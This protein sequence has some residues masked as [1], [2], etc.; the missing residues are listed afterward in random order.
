MEIDIKNIKEINNRFC[1]LVGI[2]PIKSALLNLDTGE[3]RT[4]LTTSCLYK[5]PKGWINIEVYTFDKPIYPDFTNPINFSLLIEVQW[6]MFG[7]IGEQYVKINEE[8]FAANYLYT[9]L[10]AVEI[11]KS[12]GGSDALDE[13]CKALQGLDFF[14]NGIDDVE[15]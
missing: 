5:K 8:S 13:Y 9:K 7:T 14:W 1:E 11:L 10:R 12:Y 2:K 3:L 4:Y 15:I 6:K